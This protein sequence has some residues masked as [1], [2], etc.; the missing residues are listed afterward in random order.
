MLPA[1]RVLESPFWEVLRDSRGGT[2]TFRA[3]LSQVLGS[4]LGSAFAA[5][6]PS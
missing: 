3:D 5:S 1:E 6:P 2:N 4:T